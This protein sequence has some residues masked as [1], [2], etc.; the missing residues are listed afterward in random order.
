MN[1][2]L[3]GSDHGLILFGFHSDPMNFRCIKARIWKKINEE[4]ITNIFLVFIG[5]R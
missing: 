5:Q 4:M 1:H 3:D 2:I